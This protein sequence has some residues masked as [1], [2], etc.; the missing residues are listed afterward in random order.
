MLPDDYAQ[1]K[2]SMTSQAVPIKGSRVVGIKF[3]EKSDFQTFWTIPLY[4]TKIR[5]LWALLKKKM[6]AV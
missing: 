6:S 5:F 2:I 4:M 1:M 3:N